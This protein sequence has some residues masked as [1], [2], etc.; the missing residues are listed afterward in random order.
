MFQSQQL[1]LLQ[2]QIRDLNGTILSLC[3]QLDDSERHCTDADHRADR[4][5]NQIDINSA[6]TH[7][8]LYRP[9]A[10]V[11]RNVSPILISSSPESTPDH[12][13]RFEATFCDGGHCSWFGN[14]NRFDHDGDVAEVTRV[15]W[16]PP[17]GSPAQSPPP[18]DSE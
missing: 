8:H 15:P 16:S 1:I 17:L 11:P 5:Q 9:A 14:V 6:V 7:A 10:H 4:L 3:S 18:S 13:C 12:N 2:S